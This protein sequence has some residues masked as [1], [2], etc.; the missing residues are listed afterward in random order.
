YQKGNSV[1]TYSSSLLDITISSFDDHF[2]KSEVI[3]S[4][5]SDHYSVITYFTVRN[6]P[7]LINHDIRYF[8]DINITS[9]LNSLKKENWSDI[10]DEI[11]AFSALMKETFV[12]CKSSLDK[13]LDAKYKTLN[14]SYQKLLKTAKRTL[15]NKKLLNC[16]DKS[17]EI[18]KIINE[19]RNSRSSHMTDSSNPNTLVSDFNNH[20]TTF[21]SCAQPTCPLDYQHIPN[22]A[23]SLYL[24]P[25]LK[26]QSLSS[27]LVLTS[28]KIPFTLSILPS[29]RKKSNS[30]D[31]NS[32]R[33]ISIQSQFS[34]IFKKAF[35]RRLVSYLDSLGIFSPHQYGFCKNKTKQVIIYK[36]GNKYTSSSKIINQ[37]APQVSV[38][39]PTLFLIYINDLP[40]HL[41]SIQ[42]VNLSFMLTIPMLLFHLLLPKTF[43]QAAILFLI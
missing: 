40:N 5:I 35:H 43:S 27:N 19:S 7:C 25:S 12:Q 39:G 23:T 26:Y 41:K 30:L 34:E 11:P 1:N 15:N 33:P 24:S 37:G 22:S 6:N 32:Y 3:P 20:F 28:S 2:V 9:F 4:D 14:K 16:T 18:W 29:W 38:L 10:T 8:S 17:R 42:D 36:E 21:P 31:F 13:N